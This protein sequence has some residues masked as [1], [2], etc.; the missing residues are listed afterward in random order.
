MSLIVASLIKC[1]DPR[2]FKGSYYKNPL[3]FVKCEFY[4]HEIFDFVVIMI[5]D[6]YDF[7]SFQA[8]VVC[9][10]YAINSDE[11]IGRVSHHSQC[12]FF[13][14]CYCNKLANS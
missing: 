3:S 9:V 7:V 6:F 1:N 12:Y 2:P 5:Y 4:Q 14:A 11:S 10:V 13:I 8:D